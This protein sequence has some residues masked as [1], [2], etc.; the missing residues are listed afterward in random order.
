MLHYS[1]TCGTF[2]GMKANGTDVRPWLA[3]LVIGV[4]GIAFGA[5]DRRGADDEQVAAV[6][7]AASWRSIAEGVRGD[8]I[9][10]DAEM[11]A[12]DAMAGREAGTEGFDLAASFVAERFAALGLAP[13]SDGSYL[14]EV[15]LFWTRLLPES[16][17]ITLQAGDT[18]IDLT[19]REDFVRSGGFGPGEERVDAEVV[20]AGHGI[21]APE[22][23][24]DDFAGIDPAGVILVVLSGAPPHFETDLRA[25]Y[26][27]S[28]VKQTEAASR[29]A[30]GLLVVR[31]PVDQRRRPWDRY[32]PGVG[33]TDMEWVDSGGVPFGGY[34]ELA[35]SAVLS[36]GAAERLFE[37]AGRDLSE[38]FVHH[39]AGETG[40]FPLGVSAVLERSS[41]QGRTVS[42]NVVGILAGD[43]PRLRDEYVVYTA[44]LDH[45]GTLDDGDD[46]IHNGFYDNAVGVATLLEVA[47]AMTK[48]PV[49]PRRSILFVAL[50]AEEKGLLGSS[51]FAQNPPVPIERI[52]ANLNIDMPFLG[53]PIGD[54]EAFGVEHSTLRSSVEKAAHAA[55][56]V[57]SPD[58]MPERVRFVRSDQFSFV[59]RGIPALNLKPGSIST[60]DSF[61]GPAMLADFLDN[62]YHRSSDA[63]D[64]PF[65]ESGAERFARTALLT[66]LWVASD[67]DRP[68]WN[69]G[70]FFGEKFATG[71]VAPVSAP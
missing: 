58:S 44:H 16:A 6:E 18:E 24:H 43:D 50:T 56:I 36:Q 45:L 62:H 63:G 52:V 28:T 59:Q 40:S 10:R 71:R 60:D 49:P 41:D 55:G 67:K 31:T 34:P 68:S 51:F 2:T 47:R 30:L 13:L 46:Q 25:Y 29:G 64:Q 9:R 23:E 48:L 66:G 17:R 70:D 27:S 1:R 53:F 54:V 12:D 42:A 57:L 4:T 19:I 3:A 15:E 5:C 38:L 7:V 32:L 33:R 11:L 22:Y 37:L 61:D 26:S 39:G 69:E 35:G 14:Q 20:F 8:R 65:S 21:A